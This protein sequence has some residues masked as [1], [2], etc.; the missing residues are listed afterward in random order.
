MGKRGCAD[1]RVLEV[2][3]LSS[4]YKTKGVVSLHVGRPETWSIRDTFLAWSN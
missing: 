1:V 2:G 3:G 4:L